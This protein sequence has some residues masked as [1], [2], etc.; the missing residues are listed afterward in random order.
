MGERVAPDAAGPVWAAGAVARRLGLAPTTLRSWH[1]RYGLGPPAPAPGRHRRYTED[2]VAVLLVM[3]RLV[4]QGVVP[5]VAAGMARDGPWPDP[6]EPGTAR[7]RTAAQAVGGVVQAAS[8]LDGET[9]RH[10]LDDSFATAGLVDTWDE[11]CVPALAALGR[12]SGADG[13]GVDAVLLLASTVSASLHRLAEPGTPRSGARRALLACAAGERHTLGLE[14]LAAALT[15]CRVPV[16]MLGG[17]VGAPVL[18]RA[19]DRTRPAVGVVW[20]QVPRTG[21]TGLLS[22]LV[23]LVGTVVAAG[24]GWSGRRLPP[25]V[26]RVSSL[27]EA[28]EVA[29][30]ATTLGS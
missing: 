27:V 3:A 21:R 26:V 16:V 7:K 30:R 14:A 4:A 12:R 28:T 25:A 2:D 24:P 18:S 9:L 8:R 5:A 13:T 22:Q 23:P 19:A 20:S 29:V 1:R 15:G 11:L 6:P 10:V 17:A